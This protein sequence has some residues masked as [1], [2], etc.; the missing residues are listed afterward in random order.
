MVKKIII[1][2]LLSVTLI[3]IYFYIDRSINQ[4]KDITEK[5]SKDNNEYNSNIIKDVN[6]SSKDLNGNQYIIN[7]DEGEIDLSD[8]NIIYLKNVRGL[9]KLTNGNKVT[10]NSKYG[11]YNI[12]NYDTIFNLDVNVDYLDNNII[13]QYLD[14][15]INRNSLIM[16]KNVVY[17]NLKNILKADV[18]EMN[19]QTKD[20]KIFMYDSKEKVNI[21]SKN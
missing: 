1:L 2:T 19:I 20:T 7:A 8:P 13:G 9:I 17:T 5:I 11:K 4:S 18:I 15:S 12:D 10:I 16:S 14:V 3:V 21:K 6:Y